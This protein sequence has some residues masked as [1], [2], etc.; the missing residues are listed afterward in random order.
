MEAVARKM[1]GATIGEIPAPITSFQSLST[2]FPRR[3]E[4]PV[5][6]PT[7]YSWEHPSPRRVTVAFAEW[8]VDGVSRFPPSRE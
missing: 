8:F 5:L 3:R 2:S 7:T 6:C 4:S 1:D